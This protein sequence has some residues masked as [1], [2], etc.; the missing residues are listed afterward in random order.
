MEGPAWHL[1][2]GSAGD[3]ELV[4]H[5]TIEAGLELQRHFRNRSLYR[6]RKE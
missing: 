5:C 6:S 1:G 3:G 2:T 4:F